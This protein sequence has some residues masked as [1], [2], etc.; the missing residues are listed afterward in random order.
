MSN[1][2]ARNTL[3]NVTAPGQPLRPAA[4]YFDH[5][6]T[7]AY[8]ATG[9]AKFSNTADSGDWLATQ[10]GTNTLT[11]LDDTPNGV[12]RITTGANA[13][14]GMACQ[15]NGESFKLQAGKD[16]VVEGY[17]RLNDADQSIFVFGLGI[18]DT[19]PSTGWT[20]YIAFHTGSS[21]DTSSGVLYCETAKN[22]TGGS[23]VGQE[24][25]GVTITNINTAIGYT[26]ADATWVYLRIETDGVSAVRYYVNGTLAATHTTNIPD[27][28]CL[29]LTWE[30]KTGNAA[31]E[32]CDCDYLFAVQE[33]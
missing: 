19:I 33:M 26:L 9:E 20:D 15:L 13:S 11:V 23:G 21:T 4:E 31:A 1:P 7:G 14:D 22:A 18:T 3:P 27:D 8:V 10:V 30:F 12:V 29:T 28:E 25:S 6:I 5:F 32:T 24:T 16:I 2:Y 17:F